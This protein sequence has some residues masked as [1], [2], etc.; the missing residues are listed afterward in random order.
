MR[1]SLTEKPRKTAWLR[2]TPI[3]TLL[4]EPMP[5]IGLVI[6]PFNIQSIEITLAQMAR[7]SD[8]SG[9]II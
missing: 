8:F 9:A 6:F 3:G 2:D 4:L 5:D 7:A 1:L